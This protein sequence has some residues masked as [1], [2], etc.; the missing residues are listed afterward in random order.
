[1][2]NQVEELGRNEDGRERVIV[3]VQMSP[4]PLDCPG[5]PARPLKRKEI[6]RFRMRPRKLFN[7]SETVQLIDAGEQT[8][9]R[10]WKAPDPDGWI[11]QE[12]LPR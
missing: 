1:M 4:T 11:G 5:A 7:D 8:Y 6:P 10:E 9:E 3:H 2:W 12:R